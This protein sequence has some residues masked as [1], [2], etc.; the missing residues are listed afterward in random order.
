MRWWQRL[1]MRV[2][3]MFG[4]RADRA[5]DDMQRTQA[6]AAAQRQSTGNWLADRYRGEW[7]GNRHDS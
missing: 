1:T 2:L 3:A 4:T 5:I 6:Q 7:E